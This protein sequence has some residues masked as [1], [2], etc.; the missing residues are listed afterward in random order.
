[1]VTSAEI[2]AAARAPG[3]FA[4][5]VFPG[6]LIAATAAGIAL[7]DAGVAPPLAIIGPQVASA[8]VVALLERAF[9]LHEGWNRS[10]GDIRVDASHAV[11]LGVAI[12]LVTP[13]S[14]ALG[15][16]LASWLSAAIGSPLWPSSWHVVWQ[17]LLA[18][19]VGELP[20]YWVHRLQHERDWLWRFHAVH[21]SAPRLY[22]L[23]ASRFHPVDI[24]MNYISYFVLLIALGCGGEVIA[25]F[26][27]VS[28]VHGIFQHANL[29]L[30]CGPL[31]W[32]FSMAELHRWH[33]SPVVVEANHNYGQQLIVWDV[34]FGTRWLPTDREPPEDIGMAGLSRFPMTYLAQLASPFR[35]ARIKRE[36]AAAE[37]GSSR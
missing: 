13:A 22:W 34:V 16:A 15:V 29:Q 25:L 6:V 18:L 17:L 23:N 19:V 37:I 9:P 8:V 20:Q 2:A 4:W 33:H 35:W 11:T 32:L 5:L 31:N 28:A 26:A 1:V 7:I 3:A 30:R 21:H 10:R 36:S 24:L 14:L 12:A 27:L